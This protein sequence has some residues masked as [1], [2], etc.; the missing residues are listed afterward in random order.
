ML[1]RYTQRLSTSD[2]AVFCSK[3]PLLRSLGKPSAARGAINTPERLLLQKTTCP[4]PRKIST[5]TLSAVRGRHCDAGD[6]LGNY[7]K[8]LPH[9]KGPEFDRI[10]VF[11]LLFWGVLQKSPKQD[12]FFISVFWIGFR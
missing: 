12:P 11:F 5:K 7:G 8:V 1:Y 6:E 3:P 4:M 2:P 9:R 10:F